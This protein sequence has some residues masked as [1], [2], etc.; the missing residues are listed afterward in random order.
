[1]N[2]TVVPRNPQQVNFQE[3]PQFLQNPQQPPNQQV[4][5][6]PQ[7]VS[8]RPTSGLQNHQPQQS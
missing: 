1:M 7:T 8:V 6:V 2:Q 3:P 5:W 4:I